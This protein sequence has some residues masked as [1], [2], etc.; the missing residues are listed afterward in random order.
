[1]RVY[2]ANYFENLFKQNG[3][4][5]KS[6]FSNF[7][8]N[9]VV[10]F[11]FGLSTTEFKNEKFHPTNVVSSVEPNACISVS[12]VKDQLFINDLE[13][14]LDNFDKNYAYSQS[15]LK[16]TIESKLSHYASKINALKSY[17]SKKFLADNVFQFNLGKDINTTSLIVSPYLNLFDKIMGVSD[18]VK[19][20]SLIV[21]FCSK[22]TRFFYP[23]KLNLVYNKEESKY[24]LYCLETNTELVPAFILE[25]AEAFFKDKE[26]VNIVLDRIISTQGKLSD[27]GDSWVDEHTG[28]T[29][30]Q[31]NYVEEEEYDDGFKV[32]SRDI[33]E[34]D[35]FTLEGTDL[36]I[37]TPQKMNPLSQL[38]FSIINALSINSH[39]NLTTHYSSI[40]NMTTALVLNPNVIETE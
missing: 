27:S 18:Y 17:N 1:M 24:W 25:I 9:A 34:Q 15:K 30:K 10:P 8:I 4:Y 39:V 26:S 37:N 23:N 21:K 11:L 28:R 2:Y 12:V 13:T 22:F 36:T 33:M 40:I 29:I 16:K 31:I 7:I 32:K 6:L 35:Q 5:D 38:I 3:I 20:Q 19:R 14:M